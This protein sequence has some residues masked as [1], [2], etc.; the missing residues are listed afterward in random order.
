[1][2]NDPNIPEEDEVLHRP[3]EDEELSIPEPDMDD[4]YGLPEDDDVDNEEAEQPNKS[5]HDYEETGEQP[6]SQGPRVLQTEQV[7]A[8]KGDI[9]YPSGF[10]WDGLGNTRHKR[11]LYRGRRVTVTISGETTSMGEPSENSGQ[12]NEYGFGE[13]VDV[14]GYTL[15]QQMR[16]ENKWWVTEDHAYIWSGI[17]DEKPI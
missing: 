2:S 1:M 17:T 9:R 11:R 4:I 15:G 10:R 12:V 13:K 8:S 3:E 6:T 14:L 7:E 5:Y 16:G